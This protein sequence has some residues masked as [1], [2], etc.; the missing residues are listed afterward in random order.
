MDEPRV[1]SSVAVDVEPLKPFCEL[2]YF[3]YISPIR[4]RTLHRREILLSPKQPFG[5]FESPNFFI[6]RQHNAMS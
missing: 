3:P 2:L 5:T 1:Q 4:P 6:S